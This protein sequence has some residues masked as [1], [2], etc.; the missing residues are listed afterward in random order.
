MFCST[1]RNSEFCFAI[2]FGLPVPMYFVAGNNAVRCMDS[3]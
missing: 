1:V 2:Y 3:N